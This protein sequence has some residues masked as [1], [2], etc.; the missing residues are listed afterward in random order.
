MHKDR[1]GKTQLAFPCL[2]TYLCRAVPEQDGFRRRP[3]KRPLD[4]NLVHKNEGRIM[5]IYDFHLE[6]W[7][8]KGTSDWEMPLYDDHPALP[9]PPPG[10]EI[11][12]EGEE[13]ED[14]DPPPLNAQGPQF[15]VSQ[16]SWNQM[17]T[18]LGNIEQR[19]GDHEASMLEIT[20]SMRNMDTKYDLFY[21]EMSSFMRDMRHHFPPGPHQ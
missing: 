14:D 21:D 6:K 16:E 1:F 15:T 17:Q 12:R 13:A 5:S 18:R 3:N 7:G 8:G 9:A 10:Y 11:P 20:N 19:M 2:I 4:H